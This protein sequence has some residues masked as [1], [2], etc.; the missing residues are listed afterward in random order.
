MAQMEM[1]K[2]VQ[3]VGKNLLWG[4]M[5]DDENET[6]EKVQEAKTCIS[7]VGE[8]ISLLQENFPDQ[9]LIKELKSNM[10]ELAPARDNILA[11]LL[12]NQKDTAYSIYK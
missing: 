8:I 11:L 12:E 3:M 4:I 2:N 10:S 9:E 5:T 6:K 7:R 1:A